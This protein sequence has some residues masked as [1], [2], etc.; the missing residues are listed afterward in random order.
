[1]P[2]LC[3]AGYGLAT[4]NLLYFFWSFLSVLHQFSFHQLIYLLDS[5]FYGLSQKAFFWTQ[6]EK[7]ECKPTSPFSPS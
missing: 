3:T 6:L 2:P 5:A 7:S 1:M 4:G